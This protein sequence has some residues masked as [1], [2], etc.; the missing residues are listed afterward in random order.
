MSPWRNRAYK[1]K[2]GGARWHLPS[3]A[4]FY[5]PVIQ[6][7]TKVTRLPYILIIVLS[8]NGC[9]CSASLAYCVIRLADRPLCLPHT[10]T[11]FRGVFLLFLFIE[12]PP[13]KIIYHHAQSTHSFQSTL[14]A[15]RQCSGGPPCRWLS[16]GSFQ[17][18]PDWPCKIR[19]GRPVPSVYRKIQRL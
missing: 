1:N 10:A 2:A 19:L 18:P 3:P 16:S 9:L 8:K 5:S 4:L 15:A 6:T 13:W 12:K 11:L 7:H 17:P 14:A